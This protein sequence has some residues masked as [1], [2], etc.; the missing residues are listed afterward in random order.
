MASL[1]MQ[2]IMK[3]TSPS[4]QLIEAVNFAIMKLFD[5]LV[6]IAIFRTFILF[7]RRFPSSITAVY[8]L[9]QTLDP[10]RYA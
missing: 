8:G 6:K 7:S 1:K 9:T 3:Q 2:Q 10:G 4:W 5:F